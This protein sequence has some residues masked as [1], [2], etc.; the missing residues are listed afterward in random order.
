MPRF[1]IA[2]LSPGVVPAFSDGSDTQFDVACSL[3]MSARI[4]VA[5][6]VHFD[7]RQCADTPR[8][9]LETAIADGTAQ[10]QR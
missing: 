4:Q 10:E 5:T 1:L 6:A 8:V 3:A 2:A 7:A 9:P